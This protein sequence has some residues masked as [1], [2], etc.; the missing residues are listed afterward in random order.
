MSDENWKNNEV[1]F[2][3]IICEL[4]AIQDDLDFPGLCASMDISEEELQELLD[5]AGTVWENA[6]QKEK[7]KRD[8]TP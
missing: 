4:I 5:R 7:E 2:A 6:K 1:Q 8:A 3:R